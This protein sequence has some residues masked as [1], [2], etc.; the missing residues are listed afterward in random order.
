MR[1]IEHP[2]YFWELIE[3]SQA[4]VPNS[5]DREPYPIH[6]DLPGAKLR[7]PGPVQVLPGT[8]RLQSP[9]LV[10]PA[11]QRQAKFQGTRWD[12]Q[13]FTAR[14]PVESQVLTLAEPPTNSRNPLNGQGANKIEYFGP[15]PGDSL[16][17]RDA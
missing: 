6:L 17:W 15:I 10:K 3:T 8:Y 2:F 14:N 5:K 9:I 4:D 7:E 13:A 1:Q 12:V 16:Y 11:K